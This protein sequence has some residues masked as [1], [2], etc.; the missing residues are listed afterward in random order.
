MVRS[1]QRGQG[2]Y[3]HLCLSYGFRRDQTSSSIRCFTE[4]Q[5]LLTHPLPA[6]VRFNEQLLVSN[7]ISPGLWPA[8]DSPPSSHQAAPN[9]DLGAVIVPSGWGK[10]ACPAQA[11]PHAGCHGGRCSVFPSAGIF[12]LIQTKKISKQEFKQEAQNFRLITQTNEGRERTAPLPHS[13]S[14]PCPKQP[15]CFAAAK[16]GA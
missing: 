14:R 5:N 10:D 1:E 3:G 11:E 12:H 2:S 15:L 7:Q 6:V 16:P 13:P 8:L 9:Q 4:Q